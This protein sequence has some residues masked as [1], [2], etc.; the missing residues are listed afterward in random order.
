[1]PAKTLSLT[2]VISVTITPTP[3]NLNTPNINTAALF[4][5]ETP[6]WADAF[7]IYVDATTVGDDFGTDS[8]AYAIAVAFFAQQP[9]PLS[10][11]GYLV[12][13]P[14]TSSGTETIQAAIARTLNSV[15][16]FGILIDEELY[17]TEAVFVA[18]TAYI[19]TL[20]KVL[21]YASSQTADYAPGGMLDDVRTAS[22]THTRCLYYADG[23][24]LDTQLMAAAYAGRALST[25]FDGSNTT[26]TMHMKALANVD[27]DTTVDQTALT[28]I[29]VAG[30][31]CYISIAGISALFTS[32]ENSFYDEVYNEFWL[33]FALQTAG[34]NYL[35]TTNTKIPQTPAGIEGLKN[36]Y[37][38]VC[39]QGVTNGFIGAG[40][41]TSPDT[42]GD[43]TSLI[44]CIKDQ[45]FYV[46]AAPLADQAQ[47]DRE[48]REAPL[49]QIAIKTAGAV[50][51]SDVIVNVNL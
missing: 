10:S 9:N 30:V 50:H 4:S 33:K 51:K 18:L 2:N 24:A 47:A 17:S 42:F 15:Y 12:I 5:R 6:S 21:F 35:R 8:N 20:D 46:Y 44:R 16:Y 3:T 7:K 39:A 26:Q 29:G 36:E 40:T 48:A 43:P 37:R 11:G 19:Q 49:I 14:R 22:K 32:G 38:K 27:P 45:G 31:D 23:T 25:N 28:A 1:M 34:F 13:I 41:W